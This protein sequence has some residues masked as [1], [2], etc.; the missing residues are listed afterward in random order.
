M[1]GRKTPIKDF[2]Q[3]VWECLDEIKK[4]Y[5]PNS[6]ILIVTHNG[7]C[8]MIGAYFNGIP[9]DGNLSIYAH[10]NCEIK[11]YDIKIQDI[12]IEDEER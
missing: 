8:R 4:K 11:S 2:A 9:K 10:D 5:P 1:N 3:E 7:V 12:N 6:K